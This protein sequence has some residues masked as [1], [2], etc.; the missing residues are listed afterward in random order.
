MIS[1]VKTGGTFRRQI[2]GCFI[3]AGG[4][5]TGCDLFHAAFMEHGVF[6]SHGSMWNA[7]SSIEIDGRRQGQSGLLLEEK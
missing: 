2:P 5:E 7:C 4:T 3:A 6:S 1:E